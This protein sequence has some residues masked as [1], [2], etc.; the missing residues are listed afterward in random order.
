MTPTSSWVRC[1]RKSRWI[2]DYV[3]H[4]LPYQQRTGRIAQREFIRIVPNFKIEVED[5]ETAIKALED[6]VHGHSTPL[7]ETMTIRKCCTYFRIANE[8]YEAYHR[9]CGFRGLIHTDPQNVPEELRDEVYYRWKM[10]MDVT[11]VYDLIV[12]MISCGS[13]LT[14]TENWGF[15]VWISLPQTSVSKAGW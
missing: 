15:R 10:F 4:N 8:A 12:R 11:D 6:S 5:R 3:V 2:H 1:G 13:Q 9:K 7:W 14:I